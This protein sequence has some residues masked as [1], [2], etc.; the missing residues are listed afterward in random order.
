MR[1]EA[2]LPQG[3]FE[4]ELPQTGQAF[5]VASQP[6]YCPFESTTR[7][8]SN[9]SELRSRDPFFGVDAAS[10]WLV[11]DDKARE[12]LVR[13]ARR[14][15]IS[16]YRERI[17]WARLEAEE[18]KL[19]Y[20]GDRRADFI[21]ETT[22]KYDLP[23]LE[24]FHN[25][26]D[27][28]G[29]IGAYPKD[30][31]KTAN[32][33][34]EIAER[35]NS[36]WNSIE[37][38]NEPDISFSGNL[39]ADQYV[40][41]L[42]ATAQELKRRGIETPVVGGIIASFRD[43][44]MD[45]F[46]DNGGLDACDIFSFHTYCRAYDMEN[47]CLRYHRW[48]V[49]NK[50]EWKPVWITECG[51]PW[52]KGTDR[53]NSEADLLSA[54]DIVQKG[55]VSKA[56]GIDAYFPFVYVF[57]EENDS[58]FGM[59]DRHNAPLRSCAGYARSIYLLSDKFCLGSWDVEG[60]ER[61]YVFANRGT[62]ER[63]AV[64]YARN[65][66]EGRRVKLPL[67]PVFVER[68]CGERIEVA[69]D[70]TVDF[71]DGFLY[72]GVPNDSSIVFKEP[73]EV[74]RAR[75]LRRAAR[76][77]H[78]ADP[79]RNYSLAL[80]YDY[81]PERTIANGSGYTIS[82]STLSSFEGKLTVYNFED[83]RKILPLSGSAFIKGDDGTLLEV[84]DIVGSLPEKIEAPAR[85]SVDVTFELKASEASPFSPPTIR[86]CV[87]DEDSLSFKFNRFVTPD[88]FEKF[89]SLRVPVDLSDLSRWRKNASKNERYDFKVDPQRPGFWGFD[90]KF[91]EGDKWAYPV[92][93]FPIE[94][95]DNGK[96][97]LIVSDE[98]G[99]EIKRDISEF[100]GVAF[101]VKGA[102]SSSDGV[103]RLFF[104]SEKGEY[105]FTAS[106]LMKTD[107]EK[108]FIV[109]PFETLNPYGGTPDSFDPSRIRGLSIGGN[110]RAEDLTIEVEGFQ[111]F[112]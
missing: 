49:K 110:S 80:R 41:V 55:V 91:G 61:S 66:E 52:K 59:S 90:I 32:S 24:L 50:A 30:L 70:G 95:S 12:E 58:N 84:D 2:T 87:G 97:A 92:Y 6:A 74:D 71:S 111:F 64:L 81:D 106:G 98:N 79:R 7:K 78:G 67:E 82:D 100:K 8:E 43:D 23:V 69:S 68:V 31:V 33:W 65:R 109:V 20:N 107:S 18:G 57:Y 86:F 34:G 104:H 108:R 51:R 89:A 14:I 85:G 93:S 3:Y 28:T 76:V 40:P 102:S 27:W 112:K 39:P 46:A 75:E 53:P 36:A 99:N 47:I 88:N 37:V 11:S 83:E 5:G 26:P 45:C 62:G 21:R 13:N 29:K 56:L 19:D 94:T 63:I 35:W 38:W 60:V 103:V 42:K 101:W 25:T 4:L 77:K 54:I 10:T 1:I 96:T 73:S 48:L 105:Y 17:N 15:G 16:T 72:V 9:A 22:K 44:F